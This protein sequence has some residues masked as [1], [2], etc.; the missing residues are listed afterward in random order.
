M[1][2]ATILDLR[3]TDQ[4]SSVDGGMYWI[5]SASIT[6]DCDDLGAL[7]FSFPITASV[8]SRAFRPF[9]IEQVVMQVKTAFIGGTPSMTIAS[10]TLATDII[11]TDGLVTEVDAD[12]YLLS[13]DITEATIGWYP[14]GKTGTD[15]DW[16]TNKILG[17]AVMPY[18]HDPADTTV[19]CI[20]ALL[21]SGSAI[22]AGEARIHLL[23]NEVPPY[24]GS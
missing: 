2:T 23:I 15:P 22:T 17:D 18:Y 4:R 16:I 1:T 3:R 7:L 21:T 8:Y 11:T 13:D 20:Y 5:T 14:A 19:P 12:D 6:K 24:G 10:G 9:Y